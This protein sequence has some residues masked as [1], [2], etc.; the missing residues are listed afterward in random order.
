MK[1][2]CL[3][4]VIILTLPAFACQKLDNVTIGTVPWTSAYIN[5]VWANEIKPHLLKGCTHTSFSSSKDFF[6]FLTKA[7]NH[8]FDIVNVPPHFASLL[9][10]Y[11]E[12]KP[13][14]M[15]KWHGKFLFVTAK[16]NTQKDLKPSHYRH[17]LL[18]DPLSLLTMTVKPFLESKGFENMTINGNQK[19]VLIRTIKQPNTLGVIISPLYESSIGAKKKLHIVHE[20]PIDPSSFLL[21]RPNLEQHIIQNI[22]RVL[23]TLESPS[24]LWPTWQAVHQE[25]LNKLH[26]TQRTLVNQLRGIP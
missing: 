1:S 5:N 16:S 25:D 14:N 20:M 9:I 19:N 24:P 4:L 8:Q 11:Y 10:Q 13:I 12:F 15:E 23:V 6:S 26:E 22:Q 3:L 7:I 21:A 17:V 18:P 2:S